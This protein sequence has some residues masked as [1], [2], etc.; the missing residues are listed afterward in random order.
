MGGCLL[1]E[2]LNESQLD[3]SIYSVNLADLE[4]VTDFKDFFQEFSKQ[5]TWVWSPWRFFGSVIFSGALGKLFY[6]LISALFVSSSW[7]NRLASQFPIWFEISALVSVL[8]F[9]IG[10]DR[11]LSLEFSIVWNL[12]LQF[13]VGDLPIQFFIQPTNATSG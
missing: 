13:I 2:S 7:S 1:H 3:L 8:R 4:T 9:H 10:N 6:V 12:S 5:E 11:W